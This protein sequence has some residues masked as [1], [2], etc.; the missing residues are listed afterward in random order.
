MLSLRCAHRLEVGCH[1][2]KVQ[3]RLKTSSR[4]SKSVQSSN[5]RRRIWRLRSWWRNCDG[6]DLTSH[7]Q[8][9][10][11][12]RVNRTATRQNLATNIQMEVVSWCRKTGS[13]ENGDSLR[14]TII[15]QQIKIWT[16]MCGRR[17]HCQANFK[18]MKSARRVP[19]SSHTCSLLIKVQPTSKYSLH[20]YL[21]TQYL[22]AVGGRGRPG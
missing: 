2:A 6:S 16:K 9:T 11:A 17:H 21:N 7:V 18:L 10:I 12:H 3:P 20:V 8:Y 1:I 14:I 13:K 22:G 4:F 19:P 15:Q 5:S